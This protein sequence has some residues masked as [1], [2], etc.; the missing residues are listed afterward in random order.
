MG[1]IEIAMKV[2]V[3]RIMRESKSDTRGRMWTNF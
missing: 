1:Q 2:V 3:R